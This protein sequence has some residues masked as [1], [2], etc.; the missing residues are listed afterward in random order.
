MKDISKKI[1]II[2]YVYLFFAVFY[3]ISRTLP[4]RLRYNSF[5]SE[6]PQIDTGINA[7]MQG[8]FS[9]IGMIFNLM[10]V[11]ELHKLN[12][13]MAIYYGIIVC[14][15][16]GF[17]HLIFL[18]FMVSLINP[19]YEGGVTYGYYIG[20]SAFIAC[21]I[22]LGILS[23]FYVSRKDKK[24]EGEIRKFILE[25]GT[26]LDRL[27]V[28]EISEYTKADQS[29]IVDVIKSMIEKEE[30]YAKYFKS[31][32]SVVFNQLENMDKID[33]LMDLYNEWEQGN[34][35]KIETRGK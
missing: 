8:D 22:L 31:T 21:C 5:W 28:R 11:V 27:I 20:L 35:G 23:F 12:T 9:W 32:N 26:F 13:R 6:I 10:V 30:I 18:N 2:K 19:Y 1:T 24:V 17:F 4:Y 25:Y 3:I 15:I 33:D 34:I 16:I 29:N 14:I 7:F